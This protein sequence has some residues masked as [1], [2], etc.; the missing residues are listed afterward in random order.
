MV[1]VL[2]NDRLQVKR[3]HLHLGL[4]ASA[5][6]LGDQVPVPAVLAKTLWKSFFLAEAP[7]TTFWLSLRLNLLMNIWF[8][9]HY[10][11]WQ[12]SKDSACFR[13]ITLFQY[14][15]GIAGVKQ[16]FVPLAD[17]KLPENEHGEFDLGL[18]QRT[19]FNEDA[20]NALF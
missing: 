4:S 7:L 16:K 12:V 3:L 20:L 8:E 14:L 18:L 11:L 13:E 10:L 9:G 2:L 1:L 5:N 6:M 19:A 15:L 17:V